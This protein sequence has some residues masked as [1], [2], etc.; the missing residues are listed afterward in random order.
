MA[1]A[2]RDQLSFWEQKVTMLTLVLH[3]LKGQLESAQQQLQST[4]GD[5]ALTAQVMH[6]NAQIDSHREFLTSANESCQSLMDMMV[7]MIDD[8]SNSSTQS[9]GSSSIRLVAPKPYQMGDDFNT[10]SELFLNYTANEPIDTQ[11][12]VCYSLYCPWTRFG[13][14]KVFSWG[15]IRVIPSLMCCGS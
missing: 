8:Q 13:L 5:A 1:K 12:Q 4:P 14:E 2:I 3:D 7:G 6:L 15:N 11:T 10:F 9:N